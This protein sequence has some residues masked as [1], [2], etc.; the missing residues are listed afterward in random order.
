[1]KFA[2]LTVGAITVAACGGDEGSSADASSTQNPVASAPAKP[3]SSRPADSKPPQVHPEPET[4]ASTPKPAGGSGLLQL[5]DLALPL[6]PDVSL[7]DLVPE[8]PPILTWTDPDP[9]PDP[10]AETPSPSAPK[11]N[12]APVI[13]GAPPSKVMAGAFYSFT[14]SATDADGDPLTFSVENLP[15][16]AFFDETS[17]ALSGT[18]QAA[19]VRRYD[20]ITIRVTDGKVAAALAPFSI[21]VVGTAAGAMMIYWVPPT[22]NV[23]GTPLLNLAGYSLHWG[24]APGS[25]SH[26]VT[27][28]NPG[29]TSYLVEQLTPGQW[30]FAVKAVT[31]DG[32]ESQ[33]SNVAS[34]SVL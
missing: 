19:D 22:E 9:H 14:P 28:D 25:Y 34:G 17:G 18:P 3:D 1:M 29:V 23:D 33:Y 24:Q 11:G 10:V 32:R 31:A 13:A 8:I 12:T 20:D 7:S 5:P 21:D 30:F 16:W 2:L 6:L 26:T 27:I 15:P 4:V